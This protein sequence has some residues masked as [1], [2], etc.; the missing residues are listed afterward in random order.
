M[1]PITLQPIPN[2]RFQATLDNQQYDITIRSIGDMMFMDVTINAVVV[3]TSLPCI[4][5]QPVIPYGYLEGGGGNFVWTTVSGGN[6]QYAN[7]G[8]IDVLLYVSVAELATAR[9]NAEIAKTS[10]QLGP[11]QAI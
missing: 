11:H 2:Q 4:V 8:T 9:E 3:A 10:I 1:K 7:F 5:G 6:P